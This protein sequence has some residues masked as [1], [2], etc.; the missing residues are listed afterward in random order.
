M[1]EKH[2]KENEAKEEKK[3]SRN[4]KLNSN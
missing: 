2:K 3:N 4:M 1:K